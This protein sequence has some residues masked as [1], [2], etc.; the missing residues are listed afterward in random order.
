ML[1]RR[2]FFGHRWNRR[3]SKHGPAAAIGIG[4]GLA[5]A[6]L[7]MLASRGTLATAALANLSPL[8]VMIA[9]L[10]FGVIAGAAS[11]LSAM[12]TVAALVYAQQ[13]FGHIDAAALAGLIFALFLGMPAFWLS[14]LSVLSRAKG[15]PNWV[16][17]TRVGSF[18]AR[19]YCP[20]ERV[21]AYAASICATIG[22]AMAIYVVDVYGGFDTA[23]QKLSA[24]IAPYVERMI[25]P[26]VQLP[27][28]ADVHYLA[29][30]TLLS[31]APA[32][33]AGS[34]VMLMLDLWL[35]GRIVQLSGQLPRQ[36]RLPQAY[37]LVFG[38]CA[39]AGPFLSGLPGLILIIVAAT[40]GVAFALTGLAAVHHL[41]RGMAFR[42]PLLTLVY[43]GLAFPPAWLFVV[44]SLLA[45]GIAETA[46]SLRDRK[47]RALLRKK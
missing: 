29:K 41:T 9:V 6:V 32:A 1:N 8:P 12:I 2:S 13:S 22:V 21:I 30:L 36:L 45:A 11:V 18:F 31:A 43:I 44:L 34:L 33:A 10:G 4:A 40:I 37:L 16:V 20:I 24:E 46:F 35:A 5:A 17:T 14:L 39:I 42:I 7:F 38:A 3:F 26:K 15:S 27:A 19:E 25:N 47:D 23:V 28:G